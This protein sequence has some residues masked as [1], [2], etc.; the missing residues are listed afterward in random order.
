MVAAARDFENLTPERARQLAAE[1]A[2]GDAHEQRV[3]RDLA[4]LA[5]ETEA[6]GFDATGYVFNWSARQELM[7]ARSLTRIGE[8]VA[9]IVRPGQD[10]QGY[11]R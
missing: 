7:G 2:A 4:M 1:Y 8:H 10:L 9:H 5:D 3:S 6:R 11:A